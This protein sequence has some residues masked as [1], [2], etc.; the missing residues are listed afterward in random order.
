MTNDDFAG[1]FGVPARKPEDPLELVHMDLAASVRG[2]SEPVR[3]SPM[4]AARRCS[5]F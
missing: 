1:L 4:R 2:L 5:A 3:S